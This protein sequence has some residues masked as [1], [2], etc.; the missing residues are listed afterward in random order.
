MTMEFY[1][2]NPTMRTAMDTLD[3][4]TVASLYLQEMSKNQSNP[5]PKFEFV[6]VIR[7]ER[8]SH[9]YKEVRDRFAREGTVG[10]DGNVREILLF[11]G[12]HPDSAG[13]I[14]KHNFDIDATPSNGRRKA[15]VWFISI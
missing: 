15:M 8:F 3:P 7:N 6:N 12:T 5:P 9:K 14:I 11:H 13:N 2:V 1:N 4:T 10:S